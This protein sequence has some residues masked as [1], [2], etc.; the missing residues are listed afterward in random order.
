MHASYAAEL[1]KVQQFMLVTIVWEWEWPREQRN[2]TKTNVS[3]R[4][5]TAVQQERIVQGS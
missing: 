5:V 3:N 2:E 1:R 4:G